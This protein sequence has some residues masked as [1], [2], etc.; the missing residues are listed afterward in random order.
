MQVIFT[1]LNN[2]IS[3]CFQ[4]FDAMLNATGLYTLV[5]GTVIMLIFWRMIIAPLFG[6]SFMGHGKGSDRASNK[7]NNGQNNNAR[8][9]ES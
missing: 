8:K 6:G 7:N 9:S 4:W 1:S 2:A 3:A 5:V